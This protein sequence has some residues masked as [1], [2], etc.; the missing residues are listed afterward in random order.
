[1]DGGKGDLSAFSVLIGGAFYVARTFVSG[2]FLFWC[3]KRSGDQSAAVQENAQRFLGRLNFLVSFFRN[4][5][6]R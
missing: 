3:L 5:A 6:G 2:D 4:T 1:M